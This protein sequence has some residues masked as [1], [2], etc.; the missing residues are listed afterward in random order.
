MPS[1]ISRH[2]QRSVLVFQAEHN[3]PDATPSTC[4]GVAGVFGGSLVLGCTV[5]LVTSSVRERREGRG[6]KFE[7]R[8]TAQVQPREETLQHRGGPRSFG[9]LNFQ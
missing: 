6:Q 9:R 4:L 5:S 8:T 2:L 7:S 1:A 3:Y